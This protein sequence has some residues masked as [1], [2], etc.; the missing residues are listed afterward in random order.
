M[1]SEMKKYIRPALCILALFL[2]VR[3]WSILEKAVVMLFGAAAPI[4]LGLCIAYVVDIP[5]T[6]YERHWFKRSTSPVVTKLRRPMCLTLAILTILAIV[7][8]VVLMVLPELGETIRFLIA[9]IPPL[10]ERILKSEFVTQTVPSVL[11]DKLDRIDWQG[12]AAKAADFLMSGIG[13]VAETLFSV[14]GTVVGWVVTLFVAVVFAVYA[15]AGKEKLHRQTGR[16]LR[17]GL[18]CRQ[19]P[20]CRRHE[21]YAG[22]PRGCATRHGRLV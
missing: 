14:V 21:R 5:M 4:L 3:Y 15:L 18:F 20:L 8:F 16:E 11:L 22:Q 6:F 9:E 17:H 19:F 7:V 10:F 13:S 2:C 1:S 12:L